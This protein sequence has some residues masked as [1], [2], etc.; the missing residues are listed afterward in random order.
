[1]TEE[2]NLKFYLLSIH[3]TLNRSMW[4]VATVLVQNSRPY[5]TAAVYIVTLLLGSSSFPTQV[6]PRNSL[7]FLLQALRAISGLEFLMF[8]QLD[9]AELSPCCFYGLL[10]HLLRT[11][12]IHTCGYFC[13][14]L[15]D[16]KNISKPPTVALCRVPSHLQPTYSGLL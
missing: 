16:I 8:R 15:Q 12:S 5:Y 9:I 6:V 10:L 13:Q 1:M 14:R 7:P 2:I 3:F 11:Y 4:L